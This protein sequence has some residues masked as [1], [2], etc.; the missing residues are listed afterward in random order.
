MRIRHLIFLSLTFI[1]VACVGG[2]GNDS[3]EFGV[4]LPGTIYPNKI[5]F[6]TPVGATR[7]I[8]FLHGGSGTNYHMAYNLGINTI[9]SPPTSDS[10]NWTWLEDHKVLAI[11]PQGQSIPGA[12]L[13]YTWSNYVMDSGQDDMGF[14]QALV[15]YIS[16]HYHITDV[17]LAGHSNGGMMANRVWCEDP[18]LFKAYIAM[19]GPPSEHYLSTACNPSTVQPYM[20]IVGKQDT[21]LQIKTLT[22]TNPTYEIENF[23]VLAAG[24]AMLDPVLIGEWY[25]QVNVRSPLMKCSEILDSSAPTSSDGSTNTWTSCSGKLELKEVLNAGHDID[26]L[27]M[28]SGY[29]MIDWIISFIDNLP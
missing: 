17:Y 10:V 1:L 27:Q 18:T 23:L 11:F 5:D 28:N 6:Y 19:S 12:P 22:F 9:D 24:P 29:Q 14:L 16:S 20:G 25:Q 3:S 13:A 15:S 21:V 26:S 2:G 4:T 8:V 7:A